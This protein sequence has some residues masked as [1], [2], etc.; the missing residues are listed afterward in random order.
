MSLG[1]KWR[2]WTISSITIMPFRYPGN[3]DPTFTQLQVDHFN[4]GLPL[5]LINWFSVHATSMNGS[6]TLVSGDNK[7][8]ASHIMEKE[9][10]KS[11]KK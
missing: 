8:V 9:V 5:G 4:T 7:G 6:N 10:R 11:N 2:K 3:T 1:M